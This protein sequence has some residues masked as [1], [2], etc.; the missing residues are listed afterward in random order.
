MVI[1][2][3]LF[4]VPILS[5]YRIHKITEKK[6]TLNLDLLIQYFVVAACNIPLT[7]MF[8]FLVRKLTGFVIS[9][10][11][12]YYTLTAL[13]A[14]VLIPIIYS[15]YLVLSVTPD[16]FEKLPKRFKQR[17]KQRKTKGILEELAP[18]YL[19]VFVGCFMLFIYEPL[20]MYSTNMNDF[21]F[22][23]RIMIWPVLKIFGCFLLVGIA[24]FT[25]VY[26]ANLLFS[27][28]LHVYKSL[29]VVG[30]LTFFALYLQG[31]WLAGNLPSLN[32]DEIVWDEY[33]KTENLILFSVIGFLCVILVFS[34]LIFNWKRTTHYAAMSVLLVFVMLTAALLSTMAVNHATQSK[35]TFSPTM[36]NFNTVSSNKNFLIFLVDTVDSKRCYEIM[37]NNENFKNMLDDFTYYPDTLSA[38]PVTRDSIP[39]ILTGSAVSEN[40]SFV[41]YCNYAYNH[42]PL[43]EKLRKNNYDI[44]LYSHSIFW[45]GEKNFEIKN[46]ASIY[47]IQ[48]NLKEFVLQEIKYIGYRC[49]PYPIKK[50]SRIDTLDFN[51]CKL[52]DGEIEYYVWQNNKIFSNIF[53]NRA[54]KKTLNNY[55]Q[56]V[57]CE[58]AHPPY[59]MDTDLDI[60]DNGT[61]DQK[62]EASLTLINAYIQRLKNN[63]A[64]DNSVI[65]IMADHGSEEPH[66]FYNDTK[67]YLSRCNPILFIKGINERHNLKISNKSVSYYDLQDAFCD[68][69]DGKQSTELFPELISGRKRKMMWTIWYAQ[70]HLMEY[71]TIDHARNIEGFY[72]TGN[73]YDLK[74]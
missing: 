23:F 33:G 11:S 31:N 71:E 47:D 73:V 17:V 4:F 50:Y 14:A 16:Y 64:Y 22:D 42:S 21:W 60:I 57:H 51:T 70:N 5:V 37:E 8:V 45:G 32:G 40:C 15:V 49:L 61:Y 38:F 10:D 18:A 41:D 25:I 68:L 13:T 55:F 30:F 72:P 9:L 26:F 29:T 59:N 24:I 65:V 69:I 35:D 34:V 27:S 56:F 53:I 39:T 20:L 74:D 19:L 43:F 63:N 1:F 36:E 6:I 2:I 7:K 3:N 44:N 52:L 67:N 66:L 54:L 46:S 12:G 58:G 28:R 62:V 48:I